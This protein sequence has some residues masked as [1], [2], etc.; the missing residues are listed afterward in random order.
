MKGRV[1]CLPCTV[2]AAYD[3]ALKAT[4]D[5][6]LQ[7]KVVLEII[8]WL[9]NDPDVPKLTP[10]DLH[11]RAYRI[12]REITGN[13]DPF[14]NL[15]KISNE[16]AIRVLP[17]L[18]REVDGLENFEDKFRLA[19]LGTICGNSIDFEIQGYQVSIESIEPSLLGCLKGD[20]AI[21]DTS[22][23]MKMLSRSRKVLYLLDNAGE[24]VFDKFFIKM[25]AEKYPAAV[26]VV[27]KEGPILNDATLEDAKQINLGEVA[28]VI[29]TGT[30]YIGL[31]LEESSKEFLNHLREADL[32]IAKGQG[33]YES[34]NEI[35][36]LINKPI[37]YILRA[38]CIII[39]EMLGVPQHGNVVKVAT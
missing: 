39:A 2:R 35:E 8:K 16:I 9:A 34:V 5:E 30:D 4:D 27:V 26:T 14:R 23:L 6:G 7:S 33:Y 12:A 37:V 32:I 3:I 36:Q 15:K 22:K 28:E 1:L 20:L 11:T 29:T 10:A 13:P 31:K 18:Q 38:K 19:A 25:I 24:I 17:V 21:D